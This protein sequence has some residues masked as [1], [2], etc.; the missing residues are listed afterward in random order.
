LIRKLDEARKRRELHWMAR[1][2]LEFAMVSLSGYTGAGKTTLFNHLTEESK[3]TCQGVFMTL[4]T[5]PRSLL[6]N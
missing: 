2:R 4:G 1:K 5:C 6:L 3:T